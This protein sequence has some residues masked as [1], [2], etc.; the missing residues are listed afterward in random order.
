M[1]RHLAISIILAAAAVGAHAAAPL[2]FSGK[3]ALSLERSQIDPRIGKGLERGSAQIT[4]TDAILTL[5]RVFVT[6]GKEDRGGY[7]LRLDGTEK[8]TTEGP[9]TRH[10]RLAWEADSLVLH[11]RLTAPQGEATNTVHY[12]LLDGGR[13]LEARESFR[14]PRMQYDNVW[15]FV[16]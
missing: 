10:A 4:Q 8:T 9:I 6:G 3:W 12:R 5:A 15:V 14:G 2:D 13:T 11:E 1:T 7:E 16:K